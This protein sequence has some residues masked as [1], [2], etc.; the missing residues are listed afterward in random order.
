MGHYGPDWATHIPA[1]IKALEQTTG[2]VLELGVGI[3]STPVIHMLC[4]D[5]ERHLLSF[6]NDRKYSA[7]FDKFSSRR[8]RHE[9]KH[10]D[11]WET[12]D[13]EIRSRH[14]GLVFVDHK[15]LERRVIEIKKLMNPLNGIEEP[16]MFVIHDSEDPAYG[17]DEIYPLFKYRF[18]YTKAR[19][20]TAVLSNKKELIWPK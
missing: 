4:V 8:D 12:I 5:M 2:P 16:D 11:D 7:V 19:T 15:P 13:E 6:D 18:D 3:S 10:V 17:Y 20:K 9:I 1:L 14:W